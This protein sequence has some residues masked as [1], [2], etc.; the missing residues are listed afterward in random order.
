MITKFEK[1]GK[2]TFY[3]SVKLEEIFYGNLK[4]IFSL[5]D[6]LEN[7]MTIEKLKILLNINIKK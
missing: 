5:K 2:N 4:M 7:L 1:N 6:S 3:Y